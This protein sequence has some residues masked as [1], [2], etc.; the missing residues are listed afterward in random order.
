VHKFESRLVTN[1]TPNKWQPVESNRDRV[2]TFSLQAWTT[3]KVPTHA[4]KVRVVLLSYCHY[5]TNLLDGTCLYIPQQSVLLKFDVICLCCTNSA[6][7]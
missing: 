7:G 2:C 1:W 3:D 4:A 5:D 6:V